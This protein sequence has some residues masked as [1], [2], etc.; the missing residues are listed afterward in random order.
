MRARF[1]DFS[2]FLVFLIFLIF[3]FFVLIWL[4]SFW[5]S[6]SIPERIAPKDDEDLAPLAPLNDADQQA[7]FGGGDEEEKD[8]QEAEGVSSGAAQE[9]PGTIVRRSQQ[10]VSFPEAIGAPQAV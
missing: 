5:L 7:F 3:L 4:V 10:K 2:G 8:G 9:Q 1:S 6:V